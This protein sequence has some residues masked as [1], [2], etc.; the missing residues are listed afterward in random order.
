MVTGYINACC[1]SQDKLL[2]LKSIKTPDNLSKPVVISSEWPFRSGVFI[3]VTMPPKSMIS[4][5]VPS[6]FFN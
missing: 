1:Y 6:E 3:E 5:L 4:T 2:N